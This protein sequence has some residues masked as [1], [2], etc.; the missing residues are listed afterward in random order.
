MYN[1]ETGCRSRYTANVWA[2][3]GNEDL[4]RQCQRGE[5]QTVSCFVFDRCLRQLSQTQPASH[6]GRAPRGGNQRPIRGLST[7]F[8][9]F[10]NQL[11]NPYLCE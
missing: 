3:A 7:S 6:T 8:L 9:F 2:G 5:L 11:I 10:F 1:L 4:Q